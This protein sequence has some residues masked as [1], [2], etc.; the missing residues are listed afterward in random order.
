MQSVW[1][2]G[3]TVG[4]TLDTESNWRFSSFFACGPNLTSDLNKQA[5][6]E[7]REACCWA[8]K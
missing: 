8:M 1:A 2:T 7:L 5:G 3:D 6:P 4:D